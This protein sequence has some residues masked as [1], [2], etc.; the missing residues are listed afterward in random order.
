MIRDCI[1]R[2]I[3]LQNGRGSREV[4]PDPTIGQIFRGLHNF[5]I[6]GEKIGAN[7]KN[8]DFIC[9]W[10]AEATTNSGGGGGR[11]EEERAAKYRGR[12]DK[13]PRLIP[14]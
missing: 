1:E 11:G 12:L 5:Y 3:K 14:R 8:K 4:Q 6:G 2:S 13:G 10:I 7:E 9:E